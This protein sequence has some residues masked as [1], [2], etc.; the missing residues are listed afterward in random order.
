MAEF[1]LVFAVLA[2]G[3]A[4]S[5]LLWQAVQGEGRGE[6]FDRRDAES[7]ARRDRSDAS[8]ASDDEPSGWGAEA[9]RDRRD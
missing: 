6:T 5:L 1:V 4:F 3:V 2:A 7:R 8:A 9:R